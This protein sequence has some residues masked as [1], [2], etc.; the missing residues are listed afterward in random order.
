MTAAEDQKAR[1]Y[2]TLADGEYSPDDMAALFKAWINESGEE[3]QPLEDPTP[4][5]A[6]LAPNQRPRPTRR[7]APTPMPKVEAVAGASVVIKDGK[8][9]SLRMPDGQTYVLRR[10]KD[11]LAEREVNAELN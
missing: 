1:F 11:V 2:S 8:F 10:L 5:E 7:S 6:Y 9:D 3:K 4:S